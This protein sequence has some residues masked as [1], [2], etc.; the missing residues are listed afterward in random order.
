VGADLRHV[1]VHGGPEAELVADRI[2]ARAFSRGSEIWLG[3]GASS[4]DVRLMGH[5][6]THTVQHDPAG[7]RTPGTVRR[8]PKTKDAP[9][10]DWSRFEAAFRDPNLIAHQQ[11]LEELSTMRSPRAFDLILSRIGD[12]WD[13][14]H[15]MEAALTFFI[16]YPDLALTRLEDA[17][18][19]TG[20]ASVSALNGLLA[21]RRFARGPGPDAAYKMLDAWMAA[22]DVKEAGALSGALKRRQVR[23]TAERMRQ[24]IA[25]SFLFRTNA[26]PGA[27]IFVREMDQFLAELPTVAEKDIEDLHTKVMAADPV[28]ARVEARLDELSQRIVSLVVDQHIPHDSEEIKFIQEELIKPYDDVLAKGRDLSAIARFVG[29]ADTAYRPPA[30]S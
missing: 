8:Q 15:A 28:V 18:S 17:T 23:T 29:T 22:K 12:A 30:S 4:R 9:A 16:F 6:A 27:A 21:Y 25:R 3:R 26:L 10:Q 2:G 11:A 1:Q 14:S 13:A 5:E 7:G 19:A 20:G 24:T